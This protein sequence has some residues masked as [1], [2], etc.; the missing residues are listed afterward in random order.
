MPTGCAGNAGLLG[1]AGMGCVGIGGCTPRNHMA[2]EG[3]SS[4][5]GFTS[6]MGETSVGTYKLEEAIEMPCSDCPRIHQRK[7][8]RVSVRTTS[9][10]RLRS[11]TT[12]G[13]CV[14]PL[15]SVN[16]LDSRVHDHERNG[17]SHD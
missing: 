7:C 3:D 13:E 10:R 16:C 2:Q 6:A 9:I 11:I 5:K 17:P 14:Q 15:Q 4:V 12:H 1:S 8:I